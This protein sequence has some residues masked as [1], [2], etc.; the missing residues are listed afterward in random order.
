MVALTAP[1]HP[2]ILQGLQFDPA[3]PLK[4]DFIVDEGDR[5][6]AGQAAFEAE[7]AQLAKYFLAGLTLPRGDLWVNL[8]PYE[9]E[10]IIPEALGQTGLG[11]VFLEQDYLLKNL[12]ASLIH[13]DS[14]TGKRFWAEAYKQAYEKLGTTDI[15]VDTFNK[16]WIIPEKPVVYEKPGASHV[17]YIVD[18]RLKVMLD[19]DYLAQI[20]NVV[21]DTSIS[22]QALRDIIVP[23]IEKE[24]NEGAGFAPLRQ[25]YQALILAGWMKGK[26]SSAGGLLAGGYI[27]LNKTAGVEHGEQGLKDRVWNAYL[28]AFQKGVFNFIREEKDPA[29]DEVLP[30]K[31]FSG[32]FDFDAA[33]T[34]LIVGA[35]QAP[36]SGSRKKVTFR[37]DPLR[38]LSKASGLSAVAAASREVPWSF[39]DAEGYEARQLLSRSGEDAPELL[40]VTL[41]QH[42]STVPDANIIFELFPQQKLIRSKIFMPAFPKDGTDR[43]PALLRH[44]FEEGGFAGWRF[45]AN[46]APSQARSLAAMTDFKVEISPG[47]LGLERRAAFKPAVKAATQSVVSGHGPGQSLLR[48]IKE[49]NVFGIIP[50]NVDPA[51]R[52]AAESTRKELV[53]D[54]M[55]RA[56]RVQAG[57]NIPFLHMEPVFRH[58]FANGL[59]RMRLMSDALELRVEPEFLR[60]ILQGLESEFNIIDELLT[61][62]SDPDLAFVWARG[63]IR[64]Y[65]QNAANSG[66]GRD[67]YGAAKLFVDG[68]GTKR[69]AAIAVDMRELSRVWKENTASLHADVTRLLVLSGEPYQ[70]VF[71]SSARKFIPVSGELT[72]EIFKKRETINLQDAQDGDFVYHPRIAVGFSTLAVRGLVDEDV[73][74]GANKDF[75]HWEWLLDGAIWELLKNA[76]QG[77]Y[78]RKDGIKNVS[79]EVSVAA[80]VLRIIIKDDG[81]GMDR[82]YFELLRRGRDAVKEVST[83]EFTD[84]HGQ[85]LG[86]GDSI[87]HLNQIGGTVRIDNRP[88]EDFPKDHGVTYTIEIPVAAS[89]VNA[90]EMTAAARKVLLRKFDEMF[91]SFFAGRELL[92]AKL[93]R[94][95]EP[96][97]RPFME[98]ADHVSQDAMA[99]NFFGALLRGQGPG[100]AVDDWEKLNRDMVRFKADVEAIFVEPQGLRSWAAAYMSVTKKDDASLRSELARFILKDRAGEWNNPAFSK[101]WLTYRRM[102]DSSWKEFRDV[103][104]AYKPAGVAGIDAAEGV[105][106]GREALVI[107]LLKALREIDRFPGGIASFPKL[108]QSVVHGA[109]TPFVAGYLLEEMP[110][111]AIAYEKSASGTWQEVSLSRLKAMPGA[112][113]SRVDIYAMPSKISGIVPAVVLISDAAEK[114]TDPDAYDQRLMMTPTQ[115]LARSL[116]FDPEHLGLADLAFEKMI[117]A[118]VQHYLA[119][120][121]WV[122][123][124]DLRV[125]AKEIMMTLGLNREAFNRRFFADNLWALD[126]GDHQILIKKYSGLCFDYSKFIAS[127]DGSPFGIPNEV[128]GHLYFLLGVEFM[129][130]RD[131]FSS[132]ILAMGREHWNGVNG[133]LGALRG[134]IKSYSPADDIL[135]RV[136]D[137]QDSVT[138]AEGALYRRQMPRVLFETDEFLKTALRALAHSEK[139]TVEARHELVSGFVVSAELIDRVIDLREPVRDES[140][141]QLASRLYAEKQAMKLYENLQGIEIRLFAG[142]EPEADRSQSLAASAHPPMTQDM[143]TWPE[144]VRDRARVLEAGGRHIAA[145]RDGSPLR[146]LKAAFVPY[147]ETVS[148]SRQ[149]IYDADERAVSK[150]G[151]V[152]NRINL[153]AN[154]QD[155]RL[156]ILELVR[157]VEAGTPLIDEKDFLDR[158]NAINIALIKSAV[159]DEEN[160]YYSRMFFNRTLLEKISGIDRIAGKMLT[161]ALTLGRSGRLLV[162]FKRLINEIEHRDQ[163]SMDSFLDALE[164]FYREIMRGQSG[165]DEFLFKSGNNSLAMNMVNAFLRLNGLKGI[166]HGDLEFNVRAGQQAGLREA[167]KRQIQQANSALDWTAPA[168]G[169]VDRA[170]APNGGIDLGAALAPVTQGDVGSGDVLAMPMTADAGA[171]LGFSPVLIGIKPIDDLPSILG[172]SG[173]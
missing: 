50:G 141:A 89:S 33:E 161:P 92:L 90:A 60:Q 167:F 48:A 164:A 137:L 126:I 44:I 24:V 136:G 131:A 51:Q 69:L 109:V 118:S 168:K 140:E 55:A 107:E 132:L 80:E 56:K 98:A 75:R 71:S 112:F 70:I 119:L 151:P 30:R 19:S 42:G 95:D 157:D 165:E 54:L 156:L 120:R 154:D 125:A 10:R 145:A 38:E 43:S 84:I 82:G 116:W 173:K 41:R 91:K 103:F 108:F 100:P 133:H 22:K 105:E 5:A 72:S 11:K 68:Q 63:Y 143:M 27:N 26:M 163:Y 166:S 74:G 102:F 121:S 79:V 162:Q 16:V 96:L 4:V 53:N 142:L 39:L 3:D 155:A 124:D 59:L 49:S 117:K 28:E 21:S 77:R 12:T 83:K 87:L 78:G 46:A 40:I 32:G 147:E 129:H 99:L 9:G 138:R 85:G 62:F 7:T 86:V 101:A 97:Y 45:L 67:L 148:S 128:R 104:N 111:N 158:L 144:H 2:V 149:D 29:T 171:L 1:F 113:A 6:N 88:Q 52:D 37:F 17:A 18:A 153:W 106:P 150:F 152:R 57:F 169:Q 76:H 13:P 20:K 73:H 23:I 15:P 25:A 34:P 135:K 127:Q 114:F 36:L 139:L 93:G 47:F 110:S 146:Y 122:P 35:L 115:A 66:Q 31:Y 170:E 94:A 65:D 64:H 14:E 130:L 8:S 61:T 81:E 159:P 134:A 160:Y 172:L 58:I 123:Q